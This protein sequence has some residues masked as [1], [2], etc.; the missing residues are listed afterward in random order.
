[1]RDNKAG[2][3]GQSLMQ[4]RKLVSSVSE[5]GVTLEGLTVEVEHGVF[6]KFMSLTLAYGTVLTDVGRTQYA[7]FRSLSANPFVYIP[8]QWP[9]ATKQHGSSSLQDQPCNHNE[10][11]ELCPSFHT[12]PK[13]SEA[14]LTFFE[15]D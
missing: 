1:M 4:L 5:G 13:G 9:I 6:E 12:R 11:T 2:L 8:L 15:N 3:E 10:Q 14:F 7:F